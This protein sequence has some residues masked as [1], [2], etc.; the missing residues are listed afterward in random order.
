VVLHLLRLPLRRG[1]RRGVKKG[2][3]RLL[4]LQHAHWSIPSSARAFPICVL[5]CPQVSCL[6][7]VGVVAVDADLRMYTVSRC[8]RCCRCCCYMDCT[9][10]WDSGCVL[11]NLP[12]KWVQEAQTW[13]KW[14]GCCNL[15]HG[16][17]GYDIHRG[18]TP[19]CYSSRDLF[20][21]FHS[22]F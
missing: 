17:A 15:P 1:E 14:A 3:L 8:C 6:L 4:L 10:S 21:R 22:S 19:F 11:V 5:Q 16:F 18:R 9:R 20:H 13:V 7:A 2:R 12:S